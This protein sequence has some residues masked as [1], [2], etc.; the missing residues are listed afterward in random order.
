MKQFTG[1]GPPLAG[2]CFCVDGAR[3][4]MPCRAY[5]KFRH[6]RFEGSHER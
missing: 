6:V 4:K 3:L 2:D 1:F 5:V